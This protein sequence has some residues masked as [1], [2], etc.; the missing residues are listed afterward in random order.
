VPI[1]SDY[2]KLII[3]KFMGAGYEKDLESCQTL[4]SSDPAS[5]NP[6]RLWHIR[7]I[8]EINNSLVSV[9][10]Y[11]LSR[12]NWQSAP[13]EELRQV[14][15]ETVAAANLV[16]LLLADLDQADA[17]DVDTNQEALQ[18]FRDYYAR[19]L[20]DLP[21]NLVKIQESEK[22]F[23]IFNFED[24]LSLDSSQS[25]APFYR[26]IVAERE[27]FPASVSRRLEHT[28]LTGDKKGGFL[29]SIAKKMVTNVTVVSDLASVYAKICDRVG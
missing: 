27:N 21:S 28:Y 15:A 24:V 29:L 16:P 5:A 2:Q 9:L 10:I 14:F 1:D 4:F 3:Q 26:L 25:A 23:S 13:K 20:K 7:M 8:T 19:A 18:P 6:I 22:L 17:S 11:D 12:V